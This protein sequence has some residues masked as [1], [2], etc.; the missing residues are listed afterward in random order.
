VS[1]LKPCAL[2]ERVRDFVYDC[3]R[4]EFQT[5]WT[6]SA[7]QADDL[8]EIARASPTP[9]NDGEDDADLI[10]RLNEEIEFQGDCF[11]SG[12]KYPG[13][14]GLLEEAANRLAALNQ[15]AGQ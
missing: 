7:Q 12:S 15:G 3:T 11:R 1:E 2:R 8:I 10:E 5:G 14:P 4:D 13:C 6:L 9:T